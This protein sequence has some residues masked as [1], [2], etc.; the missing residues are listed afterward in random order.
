V[1]YLSV[2]YCTR[3]VNLFRR[4]D[5]FFVELEFPSL[6]SGSPCL[7]FGFPTFTGFFP[8]QS[9]FP[10][11]HARSRLAYPRPGSPPPDTRRRTC[12][13]VLPI[14]GYSPARNASRR[15]LIMIPSALL[16]IEFPLCDPR[17]RRCFFIAGCPRRPV[18]QMVQLNSRFYPCVL[19]FSACHSPF[20]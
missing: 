14:P 17:H 11:S 20:F 10:I 12:P 13:A 4:P 7:E 16:F 3:L 19:S 5:N 15:P 2:C 6:C 8:S 18:L 1:T 9:R